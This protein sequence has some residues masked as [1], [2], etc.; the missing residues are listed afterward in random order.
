MVLLPARR[1]ITVR[2]LLMVPGMAAQMITEI[3]KTRKNLVAITGIRMTTVFV[4]NAEL[5]SLT[6]MSL[7][8]NRKDLKSPN[9]ST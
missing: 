1:V 2:V 3:L 9:V 7:V 6:V 5:N 4:I 8:Q